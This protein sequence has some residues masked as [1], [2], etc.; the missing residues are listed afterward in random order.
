MVKMLFVYIAGFA[1]TLFVLSCAPKKSAHTN[2]V[3]SFAGSAQ[4]AAKQESYI[5]AIPEE[6]AKEVHDPLS[7]NEV[8][9]SSIIKVGLSSSVTSAEIPFGTYHFYIISSLNGN[10]DALQLDCGNN[11][12]VIL[13]KPSATVELVVSRE[14]CSSGTNEDIMT[15]ETMMKERVY[16][17]A[18]CPEGY[19]PVPGSPELEVVGFCVMQFEANEKPGSGSNGSVPVAESEPERKPW[20]NI[21]A[22]DAKTACTSLGIGYDL[23]SNPEWMTLARNIEMEPRN[24]LGGQVGRGCLFRGNINES[25]NPDND[26]C[27]YDLQGRLL[28]HGPVA[29]RDIRARHFL[30]NGKEVWDL[31][32]NAGEWT[33]WTLGGAL[34]PIPTCPTKACGWTPIHA[35]IPSDWGLTAKDYLPRI[36]TGASYPSQTLG[37]GMINNSYETISNE[38]ISNET[39]PVPKVAVRGGHAEFPGKSGIYSLSSQPRDSFFKR[40]TA[41]DRGFRCVFRPQQQAQ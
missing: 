22:D 5:W 39:V 32:G 38:T 6:L 30:S 1:L 20:V 4:S 23:I 8:K 19:V 12:S 25:E 11:G 26:E 41:K 27:G 7:P 29:S 24:W 28:D 33:D 40:A 34:E 16:G 10:W 36:P 2:V 13:N 21:T 15:Y 17:P 35:I 18:N 31:A 37:M 9:L 3:L 14:E